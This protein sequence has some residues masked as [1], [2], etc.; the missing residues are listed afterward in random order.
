M[1]TGTG[2]SDDATPYEVERKF[3]LGSPDV[4][5]LEA[6]A[7]SVSQ[8][9]QTYLVNADGHA[10]RVR[11]RLVRDADG[12][13][14]Q[15]TH[16]RKVPVSA[17]VVEEY[18]RAVDAATYEVLLRDADPARVPVV[19]TRWVVPYGEHVLEVDRIDSPR[20]LWLLEVELD[21]AESITE[22]IELPA[23]ADVVADVTG[24]PAYSNRSLA[25]PPD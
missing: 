12:E 16:T 9:E 18:E 17:G 13:R 8:I 21:D 22:V 24:D 2:T 23:W 5:A 1:A 4:A 14:V 7:V 11:R 15:L 19:K 6:E 25:V 20:R 3:V 10:E